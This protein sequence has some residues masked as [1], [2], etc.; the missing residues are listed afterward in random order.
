M[1][2]IADYLKEQETAHNSIETTKRRVRMAYDAA[3]ATLN[4]GKYDDLE[5]L[6]DEGTRTTFTNTLWTTLTADYKAAIAAMPEST[7]LAE[8]LLMSGAF[9][10]TRE[11]VGAYVNAA[12]DGASYESFMKFLEDE[13]Q[14]QYGTAI[15]N[16]ARNP[17][18][19]LDQVPVDEVLRY[20]GLAGNDHIVKD[21]VDLRSKAE[22]MDIFDRLGTIPEKAIKDRPYMSPIVQVPTIAR[23]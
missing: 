9:G 11:H 20:V 23:P 4:D 16:R 22:L 8:T 6:A 19:V 21:R 7:S 1:V 5:K 17:L 14:T 18:S 3:Q 13:R 12:K 2:T 10:F 15:A